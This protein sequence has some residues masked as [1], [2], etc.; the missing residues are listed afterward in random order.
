MRA[1]SHDSDSLRACRDN[2][3]GILGQMGSMPGVMQQMPPLPVRMN[4]ELAGS[5]LPK[6]SGCSFPVGLP[7]LPPAAQGASSK[8]RKKASCV[9]QVLRSLRAVLGS[10]PAVCTHAPGSTGEGCSFPVGLPFLPPAEQG[11]RY[12]SA[13]M[14]VCFTNYSSWPECHA[15]RAWGSSLPMGLSA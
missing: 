2:L 15:L 10:E 7:F 11:E 14:L 4:M 13:S 6:S 12:T 8:L 9:M 3:V 1:P 5:F